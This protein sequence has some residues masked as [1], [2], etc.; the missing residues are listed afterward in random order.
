MPVT[1]TAPIVTRLVSEWPRVAERMLAAGLG[2]TAPVSDLP[3]DHFTA[4]VL[5]AIYMCGHAFLR[6]AQQGRPFTRAEVAEFVVPVAERHAED[7]IP[8]RVL[9]DAIH[10][11]AQL[12]VR[13]A[14]ALAEPGDT[15]QLVEFG[16][17]LLELMTHINVTCVE[18]YTDVEQ[19]IYNAER[20]ARRA[21]CTALLLGA[22]A[23]EL[24]ARANTT[25]AEQYTVLAIR[26]PPGSP[27]VAVTDLLPRR[28]IR[29]LQRTLDSL[30][31]TTTLNTFDGTT[32]IALLPTGPE[33]AAGDHS[34]LAAEL[35]ERFGVDVF[36]AECAG[37]A[38]DSVP[39]AAAQAAE[40]A[41]LA[42]LLG[43]PT[44]LYHLDDLLLEYQLTRPGPARDR[45]AERLAVLRGSGH[46]MEAVAAYLRHGSD[47]KSA[48]A[49][50]HVHPNTFSYR[51]RRVAELTGMD[52]ADPHGS[53]LLAAAL[54]V[55][56][57]YPTAPQEDSAEPR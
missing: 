34:G 17:Q 44:G 42:R 47:R 1:E 54:I 50:V 3:A 28:R 51:L 31:A 27:G 2:A 55:H 56:R 52:P 22:P 57:L 38:R 36:V 4:E 5:P 26:L 10:G 14:G 32:G 6:A 39:E 7:R 35:A 18:T 11:S 9:L 49:E 21:L 43:R 12:V 15:A 29:Q 45:L 19:S 40:V 37:V 13:E 25:L 20:E 48:A 16:S 33:L 41:D 53:R 23:A 46:L 24:A 8:L 30:T